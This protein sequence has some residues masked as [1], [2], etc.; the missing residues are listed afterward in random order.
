MV[1]AVL[2]GGWII[3][4]TRTPPY[5]ADLC[6]QDGK[7]VAISPQWEGNCRT[8]VD[9][10]GKI[11]SPGFID[12]HTHSDTCPFS[13]VFPESKVAQGITLEIVGNCGVSAVPIL[14]SCQAEQT[15]Y[16]RKISE[17]PVPEEA[18][19]DASVQKYA[20]HVAQT[21]YPSHL[22]TLIGQGTLRA[23]IVGFQDRPL[24]PS[25]MEQM[26]F[27]LDDQL[28][29]GAL[30]LSLGLIYPP[31][32]FSPTSELRELARVVQKHKKIL[33]VHMRNEGPNIFQAVE[34]MLSIAEETG[35]HLHIS[36]LKLMGK[37]QWGQA[38]RLLERIEASRQRGAVVTCDQYPYTATSTILAALLPRRAYDGGSAAMLRRVSDPDTSLLRDIAEEMERRG[39]A[40]AVLVA[41]THGSAPEYHG[42]TVSQLSVCLGLTPAE[43][44]AHI[45]ARCSG[46]VSAIYFSMS[47]ED[48]HTI[49]CDM[50]V[51]I[52]SDGS[53][54]SLQDTQGLPSPHPR[55]IATFPRFLQ[56]VREHRLMSLQDAVYKMTALPAA[57]LGLRDRGTLEPGKA[58]DITVFDYESVCDQCTFT[59]SLVAPSGIEH[60]LVSGVFSLK[61][62]SIT[63]ARP[64]QVLL[65]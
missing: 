25:E 44:V 42:K 13:A 47:Q 60:V 5:Q 12:I 64:G 54:F 55:N 59:N 16:L 49:M 28:N 23:G 24:T 39:G 2:S 62:G 51:A 9:V 8:R 38:P 40:D 21:G 31:G 45:L 3:D 30:G 26:K 33:A 50:H 22:G 53:A 17:I 61:S 1:D 52:G 14:P 6:I 56:T 20:A 29:Q 34:E 48:V 41:S 36:H 11:V 32:S 27:L 65:R 57:I 46:T 4:G 58:A 7:I 15:A 19:R 18:V 10:T 37:A 35:V 43:T 63:G